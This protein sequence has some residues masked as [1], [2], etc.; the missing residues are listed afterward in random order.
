MALAKELTPHSL[1]RIG[2]AFGGRDHSSVLYACDKVEK[3]RKQDVTFADDYTTLRR[4][5]TS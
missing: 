2:D 3:L 5:L 1:S 4:L